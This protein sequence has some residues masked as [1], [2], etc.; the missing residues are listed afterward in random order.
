MTLKP[1]EYKHAKHH[2]NT[3]KSILALTI[4]LG[5]QGDF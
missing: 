3:L 2:S 4:P 1:T 5:V